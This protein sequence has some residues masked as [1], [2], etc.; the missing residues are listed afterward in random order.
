MTPYQTNTEA[1]L[2][3]DPVDVACGNAGYWPNFQFEIKGLNQ[4]QA[5]GASMGFPIDATEVVQMGSSGAISTYDPWMPTNL[6]GLG[7]QTS[8]ANRALSRTPGATDF[9]FY[10]SPTLLTNTGSNGQV[11]G[12]TGGN[13]TV[14]IQ[15][16]PA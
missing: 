13:V 1:I 6:Y 3:P 11:F 2:I 15:S 5:N 14:L 12:F 16:A 8:I 10:S 7:W 4:F 9:P